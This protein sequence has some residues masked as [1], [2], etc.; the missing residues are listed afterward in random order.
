MRL[1]FYPIIAVAFML[2]GDLNVNAERAMQIH[3]NE[4]GSEPVEYTLSVISKIKFDANGFNLIGQDESIIDSFDFSNVKKISFI[5]D[6][7]IDFA[8]E[9]ENKL[10]VTPNPVK[11]YL[12]IRGADLSKDTELNLYSITGNHILRINSWNGESIDVSYL[13]AGIYIINLNSET[14]KFVKL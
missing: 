9:S 13:P 6:S 7:R 14:I 1:K 8:L 4:S 12:V 11:D 2:L 10:L 5:N 3:L